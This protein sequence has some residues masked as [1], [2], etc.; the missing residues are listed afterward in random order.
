M[1][2]STYELRFRPDIKPYQC[3]IRGCTRTAEIVPKAQRS[4]AW[5]LPSRT[6]DDLVMGQGE[7]EHWIGK[8]LGSYCTFHKCDRDG[9]DHGVKID[10][11]DQIFNM[12]RNHWKKASEGGKTKGFS[13]RKMVKNMLSSSEPKS[14]VKIQGI[15]P[16]VET[17]SGKQMRCPQLCTDK[18]CER[19][20]IVD[21]KGNVGLCEIH[22]PCPVLEDPV[23]EGQPVPPVAMRFNIHI[24]GER[25]GNSPVTGEGVAAES[26]AA[27]VGAVVI[28][29]GIVA[30]LSG[31]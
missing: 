18:T 25:L 3:L 29:N 2:T 5:R 15:L 26:A 30:F 14:A 21:S 16:K 22:S 6:P 19:L 8:G 12:C 17:E 10:E 27:A 24:T 23:E 9:C 31:Q 28:H 11:D 7:W 4:Q 13:V 20:Q 1:N